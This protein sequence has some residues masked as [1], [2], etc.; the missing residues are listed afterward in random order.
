MALKLDLYIISLYYK[1]SYIQKNQ[2]SCSKDFNRKSSE[3]ALSEMW[4]KVHCFVLFV[5]IIKS[6]LAENNDTK[7][8]TSFSLPSVPIFN[9]IDSELDT[10]LPTH[11]FTEKI[12]LPVAG[13]YFHP[14]KT[15]E[16]IFTKMNNAKKF[17]FLDFDAYILK[18][19]SLG[20]VSPKQGLHINTKVFKKPTTSKVNFEEN[21]DKYHNQYN[22]KTPESDESEEVNSSGEDEDDEYNE[23]EEEKITTTTPKYVKNKKNTKKPFLNKKLLPIGLAY[24]DLH[25]PRILP[26]FEQ[27]IYKSPWEFP[28]IESA[29]DD[30]KSAKRKEKYENGSDEKDE[31]I[32]SLNYENFHKIVDKYSPKDKKLFNPSNENEEIISSHLPQKEFLK[33]EPTTPVSQDDFESHAPN[34]NYVTNKNKVTHSYTEKYVINDD[35]ES[36]YPQKNNKNIKNYISSHVPQKYQQVPV[37]IENV[38]YDLNVHENSTPKLYNNLYKSQ[39]HQ[40]K[41]VPQ[42]KTVQ[43]KNNKHND[44]PPKKSWDQDGKVVYSHNNQIPKPQIQDEQRSAKIQHFN[45]D[46]PQSNLLY[47]QTLYFPSEAIKPHFYIN[48]QDPKVGSESKQNSIKI[49]TS[50]EKYFTKYRHPFND[51]IYIPKIKA[52][53]S[54]NLPKTQIRSSSSVVPVTTKTESPAVQDELKY[55]Q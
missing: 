29:Y 40:K 33:S 50:D 54:S 38:K 53:G 35:N 15:H 23:E 2:I 37:K 51:N 28:T 55:F 41:Y 42:I 21:S 27:S 19:T 8:S 46:I 18:P 36:Q 14:N 17:N 16:N 45:E 30:N 6:S 1:F 43:Y 25:H 49:G 5:F 22:L 9:T 12:F 10:K 47:H 24:F 4:F 26:R 39:D 52:A 7:S 48:V 32:E 3:F 20:L 13:K 44:S 11:Q 31:S 34:G